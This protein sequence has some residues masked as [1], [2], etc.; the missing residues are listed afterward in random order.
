[1]LPRY[2]GS[3]GA[4]R[5]IES[6]LTLGF[7]VALTA[8]GSSG[9]SGATK[10]GFTSFTQQLSLQ[11]ML[12][13]GYVT[14]ACP[15]PHPGEVQ[16]GGYVYTAK[17]AQTLHPGAYSLAADHRAVE[18]HRSRMV[19]NPAG[20]GP[21][22]FQSF[23]GLTTASATMGA[24]RTVGI[25]IA[26]STAPLEAALGVYRQYYGLPPCT[27]ANGCYQRFDQNGGTNY[28]PTGGWLSEASLDAD[29]VS[30]ICPNC[31]ISVFE[32]NTPT[33]A[34]LSTAVNTAAR[35]KVSVINNSYGIAETG[36]GAYAAA[37][38]H[39][40]IPIT[41]AAGNTV[42]SSVQNVPAAFSTVT[43]VGATTIYPTDSNRESAW[44]DTVGCSTLVAKPA[45]Q[46]DT[47]CSTR[48]VAD[49]AFLGNNFAIYDGTQWAGTLGTSGGSAAIA[50]VYA[51]SGSTAND[52]SSLYANAAKLYD[53]VDG[54]S[55]SMSGNSCSPPAD[56]SMGSLGSFSS[57]RR[58]SSNT[59][60]PTYLCTG[61][62]GYDA[63]T[64]NGTPN[65]IGAFGGGS[66]SPTS[67]P[68]PT[69][70]PCSTPSSGTP[71]PHPTQ[72]ANGGAC[73]S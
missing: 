22:D 46:H 36:M 58:L 30:A 73:I 64:G 15:T 27:S 20:L 37:Y 56:S 65:G 13:D 6:C 59:T 35:L 48:T 43:A 47:A 39:P 38:N 41:A 26:G 9:I 69:A 50:A 10:G 4:R 62:P 24:G 31:N 17:G 34:D 49:I 40:G 51:L 1:M 66:S 23:Y 32:A 19:S 5:A 45:W 44:G 21:P 2:H 63:P 11:Q 18:G 16:C 72:N 33:M 71:N 28:P 55:G 25:I 54:A 60:Y 68:T 3:P 52:A 29:M 57:T 42:F 53:V 61:V 70:P 7:G 12:Q 67:T 8:C 14:S